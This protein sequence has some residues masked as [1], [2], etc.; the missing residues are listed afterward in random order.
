MGFDAQKCVSIVAT[1]LVFLFCGAFSLR[2]QNA[3]QPYAVLEEHILTFYYG[4]KPAPTLWSSVYDVDSENFQETWH[5]DAMA[6]MQVRFDESF[7]SVNM[8]S[9]ASMFYGCRD[10]ESVDFSNFCTDSITN[11]GSMFADC[12]KLSTLDLSSFKTTSV[13][14]MD[15]MFYYCRG[16]KTLDISNFNMTCVTNTK[17]MFDG[18]WELETL[19]LPTFNTTNV[20][21]AS[22]MFADCVYLQ[23]LDL[24]G[25]M[26]A[27]TTNINSMFYNCRSLQTLNLSSN[28]TENVTDM[29]YLFYYCLK[30]PTLNLFSFNT[31]NVTNMESMFLGCSELKTIYANS[32]KTDKVTSSDNMFWANEKLVGAVPYSI[33]N[34]N[35]T[36]FANYKTGY[37]SYAYLIGDEKHPIAGEPLRT[38]SLNLVDGKRFYTIPYKTFYAGSATYSR[39]VKHKWNT[40]CLPYA[41]D[42]SGNSTADFYE[43]K[44]FSNDTIY[45]SRINGTVEAGVPVIASIKANNDKLVVNATNVQ[46]VENPVNVFKKD[47]YF[48]GDFTQNN[49]F[50]PENGYIIDNDCF[51]L[52][53][54]LQNGE[55]GGDSSQVSLG[56]FRAYFLYKG[57][58]VAPKTL[59]IVIDEDATAI[60]PVR[61]DKEG[62]TEYYDLSGLRLNA[63]QKG[64]NIIKTGK[65]TKKVIIK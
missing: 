54:D 45:L 64:V 8:K 2:A 21:D 31:A 38:D 58:Q 57:S 17:S 40:L 6:I 37:F 29:G 41:F 36:S 56:A 22:R 51:K 61:I 62:I 59:K 46:V 48:L 42:A 15:S 63:P 26:N 32:F 34:S 50:V 39:E 1:L 52:C 33:N 3:P 65:K 16:L 20:I 4:V 18:C 11:M 10:L 25:F 55:K 35:D 60:K 7:A 27:S 30:L 12:T 44:K 53:S 28:Y 19:N 43:I 13:T 5:D 9:S 49:F 23:T 14:N 47:F 24:S